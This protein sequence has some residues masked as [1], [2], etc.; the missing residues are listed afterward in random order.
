MS[1]LVD[2]VTKIG[3]GLVRPLL[4]F[5]I[6]AAV[7]YL[8]QAILFRSLRIWAKRTTTD[9]DDIVV[10]AFGGPARLWVVILAADLALKS[11]A[12]SERA[13]GHIDK[14]LIILWIL[15]LTL[16]ISKLAT[17][18]FVR[19]GSAWQGATPV[20]TLG[21]N[22][23]R[24]VIISIGVLLMLNSLGISVTPILTA[25]G[26]GAWPSHS[27]CRRRSP[28]SSPGCS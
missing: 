16:A 10:A 27:A 2:F 17:S 3:P 11:A 23:I 15:S 12:L 14:A 19:Y 18:L 25:L 5:A 1:G 22:L 7:G 6:A 9:I 21:Q 13:I 28:T 8:V 26:V 20:T 24:L 4:V